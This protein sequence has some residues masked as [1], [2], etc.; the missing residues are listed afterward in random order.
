MNAKQNPFSLYDFLGYFT[1]GAV[2]LYILVVYAARFYGFD[3]HDRLTNY[4]INEAETYVALVIASYALGHSISLMSSVFVE[5][6]SIWMHNY[7]AIYLIYD[8]K[9]GYIEKIHINGDIS[10]AGLLMILIR[11]CVWI[12]LLPVSLQDLIFGIGFNGRNTYCK[13]VDAG[14]G[15]IIIDKINV[16]LD[17][18]LKGDEEKPFHYLAS[19]YFRY[20]LHYVVVNSDNHLVSLKNYVALYGFTRTMTF[21]CVMVFWLSLYLMICSTSESH[22]I[23]LIFALSIVFSYIYYMAFNKFYRRYV[24]EAY[25]ALTVL[26]KEKE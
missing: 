8:K 9:I 6:F 16:F 13:K 2:F 21:L 24:L 3:I 25:M 12:L 14:L 18:T 26:I 15:T 4:G 5:K 17:K 23:K 20:V 7:P 1:P 22:L 11:I 19:D 10:K